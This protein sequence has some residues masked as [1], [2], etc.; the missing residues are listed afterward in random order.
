[1]Q[2]Q[3]ARGVCALRALVYVMCTCT[4]I[5]L[6]LV[7]VSVH[8]LHVTVSTS[9]MCVGVYVCSTACAYAGAPASQRR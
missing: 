1:M 5:V 7:H 6:V 2:M 4:I 3:G 8:V 9:Y